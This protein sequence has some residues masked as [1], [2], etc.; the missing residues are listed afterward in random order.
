MD[1]VYIFCALIFS[2]SLINFFKSSNIL[3]MFISIELS[4]NAL[5]I[6]LIRTLYKTLN[7][8]LL[9]LFMI[10]ITIAAAEVGIGL[11]IL[12]TVSKIENTVDS[13]ILNKIKEIFK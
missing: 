9:I 6:A 4:L 11:A 7:Y 10:T 1:L 13:D 8:D 2:L 3:M 12:I 5:N